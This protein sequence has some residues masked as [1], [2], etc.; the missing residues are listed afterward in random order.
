MRACPAEQAGRAFEEDLNVDADAY[1]QGIRANDSA[2]RHG[3]DRPHE[4]QAGPQPPTQLREQ[5]VNLDAGYHW[6]DAVED[7]GSEPNIDELDPFDCAHVWDALEQHEHI[8]DSAVADEREIEYECGR[9]WR[10]L[11]PRPIGYVYLGMKE[12]LETGLISTTKTD[13]MLPAE[14]ES[15][16]FVNLCQRCGITLCKDCRALERHRQR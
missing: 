6:N 13:G 4:V 9:C 12:L 15:Q 3:E 8:E 5:F 1:R 14:R 16:E 7:F 10:P 11:V 2:E